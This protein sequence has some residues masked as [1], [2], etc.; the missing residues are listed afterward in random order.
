MRGVGFLPGDQPRR[1]FGEA[2]EDRGC[3]E[4]VLCVEFGGEEEGEKERQGGVGLL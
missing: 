1:A 3:V 4:E 2:P